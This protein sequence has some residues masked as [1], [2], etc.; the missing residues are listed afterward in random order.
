MLISEHPGFLSLRS[1][2][3]IEPNTAWAEMQVLSYSDFDS[4][5]EL[6]LHDPRLGRSD[7]VSQTRKYLV[8]NLLAFDAYAAV[9]LRANHDMRG[10]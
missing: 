9:K 4:R 7:T 10:E 1:A 5:Y 3:T 8:K 2:Q 6:S